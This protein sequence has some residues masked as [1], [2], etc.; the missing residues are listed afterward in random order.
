MVTQREFGLGRNLG[1]FLADEA[2]SPA[3][4][5]RPSQVAGGLPDRRCGFSPRSGMAWFGHP[6]ADLFRAPHVRLPRFAVKTELP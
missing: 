3:D 6:E 2:K 5:L 4:S 1:L